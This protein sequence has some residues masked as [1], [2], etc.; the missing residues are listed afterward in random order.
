MGAR[1]GTYRIQ[2]TPEFGFASAARLAS[3]LA[4]L[5]VTHLYASPYLQA[6]A[7]SA[8]GYDVVDPGRTNRELGGDE[9]RTDMCTALSEYGLMQLVDIVPNHMAI[10]GGHNAWWWDV[11]ENG[12]AS[13]Y[14]RYFDVEWNAGSDD[15]ILLPIL[16]DQYGVELEAGRIRVVRRGSRFFITYFEHEAPIA[17]RSLSQILGR[18]AHRS[19]SEELGFLADAFQSLPLPSAM[20]ADSRFRR[21]RDKEV[22]NQWLD[23]LLS[24]SSELM[25]DLDAALGMM[26]ADIEELHALVEA[27]NYR[28]AYWRVGN[29]ELAYRRFF[30][31]DSLVGLRVEDDEV[32]EA[33]HRLI[34]KWLEEE[35]VD[36][37]RIDH[38]D[39]LYDPESY[40]RRLRAIAPGAWLLVEKILEGHERV[41]PGWPVDGT[42]G[43]EF[44][45]HA[46][47]VLV[48]P[49][50]EA[51]LSELHRDASL[52][53]LQFDELV[54]RCKKLVLHEAL[55]S[56]LGRLVERLSG[57]VQT[58]RR[59]RDTARIE[60]ER[61]LSALILAWPVYRTY[62]SSGER[63]I[64]ESDRAIVET[65]CEQAIQREPEIDPRLFEFLKRLLLLEYR[66]AESVDF[67]MRFQQVTGPAM[68]K[69]L[70]DTAF[71]RH[72]RLVALNEVGGDPNHFCE[73][74]EEFHA[75]CQER[76]SASP[77]ALNA[78]STHDTKRSEDV[79]ARLLVLSEIP[80][81]WRQ[82]YTQ[83][84]GRMASHRKDVAELSLTAPDPDTEHFL[85][86]NLIGAWP[87]SVERMKQFAEKAMRE[88]KRFT[89]WHRVE[90]NYEQAVKNYLDALYEDE[91]LT[92][93][94]DDFVARITDG[95]YRNSLG[96]LLF[97]TLCP[98][99]PDIYQGTE[100]WDF[101]LV[102]PD[103]RRVVDFEMRNRLVRE[104]EGANASEL[105]ET[106]SD[107]RI[108]LFVL[109]RLL[110][111]RGRQ[112]E[113]VSLGYQPLSVDGG[114]AN[115][116]VAF[117]RGDQVVGIVTRYWQTRGAMK[118]TT[119]HLPAGTF[120]N[121]LTGR[122]GFRGSVD[123]ADLLGPL[124]IGALELEEGQ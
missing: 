18:A 21:H 78:T 123:L 22:L 90:G 86:Q 54:H 75:F 45:N 111:L 59:H 79:R 5:G 94:V 85:L 48:D 73:S 9:G 44:L 58:H 93:E 99:V 115:R 60:L 33:T 4:E 122:E 24:R 30:D 110:A 71:Y 43:Y 105:W 39:G 96:Q 37:L 28:L 124:P 89:S 49:A 6:A 26:N 100:L 38:V 10:R 1:N 112:G 69:G 29:H 62:I 109:K 83:I 16:G 34:L 27:Q 55:D 120:T 61:A 7:G 36:G 66:E 23:S 91:S 108:K 51:P 76:Q 92:R 95:G 63:E 114:Q 70:E 31:I 102:D 2:L 121:V 81:E 3:Y 17:P 88:A 8:H 107:G 97:K 15:K 68:A 65:A 50:G 118:D 101:S 64:S 35:S 20:D 119:V 57:I 40:L 103:N 67:V 113:F 53:V 74:A 52:E 87:I 98:G 14:S 12:P 56:D 11:L 47:R 84:A 19:G 13:R 72:H 46:Q 25:R 41:S 106:R 116:V 104:V 77:G 42:T 32:F 82:F 80:A 117:R